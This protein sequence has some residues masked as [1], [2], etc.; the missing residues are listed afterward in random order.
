M[1]S[2]SSVKSNSC[3]KRHKP[4]AYF[5]KTFENISTLFIISQLP[6]AKVRQ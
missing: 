1:I 4:L 6:C 2:A 5:R 3:G